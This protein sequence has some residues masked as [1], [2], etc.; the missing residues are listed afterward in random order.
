MFNSSRTRIELRGISVKTFYLLMN[1]L[2]SHQLE[3][4]FLEGSTT[5]S[6]SLTG[7][8]LR[9]DQFTTLSNDE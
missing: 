7:K 3:I 5:F 8:T 9:F 2:C 1:E 4:E 6:L